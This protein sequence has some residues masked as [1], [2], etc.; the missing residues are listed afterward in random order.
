MALV[1]WE[2]FRDL[3]TFQDR[4]NRLF[5]DVVSQPHYLDTER[6]VV[7]DWIP[8]VDIFENVDE[9]LIK[10]EL[11][12]MDMKDIEVKVEDH[13]LTLKGERHL[14]EEAKRENYHRV[15]RVYGT[16][17]RS[18]SLPSFVDAEKIRASYDLGILIVALPKKEET[19]P[20]NIKIDVK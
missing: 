6:G 10:T 7:R 11:P 18:F 4:V 16:F 8:A 2:P 19:R 17:H 5:N 3:M 15:E 20:R 14:E 13:T 9:I 12:G 1:K